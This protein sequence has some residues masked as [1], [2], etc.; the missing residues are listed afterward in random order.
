MPFGYPVML[1][2]QGRRCLVIGGGSIAEGKV[3]GLLDGRANVVV[4]ALELTER[5]AELAEQGVITTVRRH[6]REGDLAGALLAIAAT[7]DRT[8]N[9]RVFAEGAATGVLVNTVDDIEYCH[10]AAP[11]VVRRG[12]LIV[13]VSTG[14]KAPALAKKLRRR[15][16]QE[17]GEDY[18]LLLDLL[19]EVREQALRVRTV[20]FD[21]WAAR[22]EKALERD[23]LAFVQQGRSEQA[24]E[25]LWRDLTDPEPDS[26]GP[27]GRVEAA[28]AGPSD[29][30][31]R[32]PGSGRP[33][34]RVAI[35]G[36]GPEPG[37]GRPAGR[38]AIVGAGP[39]DAEL[40]TVRGQRELDAAGVVV[41][42]RLVN[43]ELVSGKESIYV[44]K[45]PGSHSWPQEQINSL[46]VR[47][48]GQGRRVV[49]L[50][51]GDPFVF[52]RGGE[53]AE[54][55][56]AAGVEFTVV[57]APTSAIAALSA[58]GIPVT[59]RRHSSSVTIVT[60]HCGGDQRVDWAAIARASDTIVVLMGLKNLPWIVAGLLA[61]GRDGNTPAAVVE[62]GT[63]PSQRVVEATL[64]G[65]A[66]AVAG[67][68]IEAP[69][70]VV[71]GEVV[72][73]RSRLKR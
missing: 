5:L 37:S 41:Y 54:A 23:L 39:G 34:G 49:R 43:P 2:I 58:A 52:G 40:I 29:A 27:G 67:A 45:A 30:T 4:I 35:V 56:A 18:G 12:D 15:F 57:P 36:A 20:S 24:R 68:G 47:L 61:G 71:V 53:E 6:Y 48:A 22:W 13:A 11:S 32:E 69:A 59:D 7:D 44:G 8:V 60:G 16:E 14:G 10:F 46:L 63:L 73:V 70:V 72:S 33:A 28:G 55:L 51:G 65:L 19:G 25:L 42:D 64:A 17:L 1:E 31:D 66:D 9:A 50:K 38:V 21:Q 26:A 3:A 62:N